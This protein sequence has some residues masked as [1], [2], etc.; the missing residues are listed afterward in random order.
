MGVDRLDSRGCLL[1]GVE[2]KLLM[3][4]VIENLTGN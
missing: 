1:C 2:P 3:S 4:V